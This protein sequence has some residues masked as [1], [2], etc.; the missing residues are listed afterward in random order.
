M[1][2][3]LHGLQRK[4]RPP[5]WRQRGRQEGEREQQGMQVLFQLGM[6][7]EGLDQGPAM[8]KLALRWGRLQGQ[9]FQA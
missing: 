6:R 4:E 3:V 2:M 8:E 7:L 1:G 5:E 9:G